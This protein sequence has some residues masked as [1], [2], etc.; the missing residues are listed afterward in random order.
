M[1]H[2]LSSNRKCVKDEEQEGEGRGDSVRVAVLCR[3]DIDKLEVKTGSAEA[4]N[5]QTV[6]WD[7]Q[8]MN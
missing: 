1:K 6:G 4:H 7:E 2:I 3:A 8:L 5:T